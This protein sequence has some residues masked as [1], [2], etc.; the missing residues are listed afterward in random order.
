MSWD[1]TDQAFRMGLSPRV[2]MTSSDGT[3]APWSNACC[4]PGLGVRDIDM[5]GRAPR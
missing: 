5:M 4:R 3:C 1:V 2:P